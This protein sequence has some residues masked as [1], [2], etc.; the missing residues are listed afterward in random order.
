MKTRFQF[1]LRTDEGQTT[2]VAEHELHNTVNITFPV[3]YWDSRTEHPI[4]VEL[5]FDTLTWPEYREPPAERVVAELQRRLPNLQ[6]EY[7]HPGFVAVHVPDKGMLACGGDSDG[8]R[9][10]HQT[11]FGETYT[12]MSMPDLELNV[13]EQDVN[14]IVTTLI[15]AFRKSPWADDIFGYCVG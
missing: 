12:T 8:W 3:G 15:N 4:Y 7:M 13:Y 11:I 14:T 5:D 1:A 6:A 9:I 2:Y 10:D